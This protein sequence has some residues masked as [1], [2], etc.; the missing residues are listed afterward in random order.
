MFNVRETV[1]TLFMIAFVSG[2]SWALYWISDHMAFSS[3][4]L[5]GLVSLGLM[6]S[7]GFAWDRYEAARSRTH[8]RR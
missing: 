3:F 5:F 8:S 6:V 2:M 1:L 7:C 4:M